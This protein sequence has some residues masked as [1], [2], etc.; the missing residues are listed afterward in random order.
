MKKTVFYAL[1]LSLLLAWPV[2]AAEAPPDTSAKAMILIHADS[3][4][5]LSEREADTPLPM[6]STTKLMTA[7]AAAEAADL[8][9]EIEIR[10]E[11]TAVEGSSM[12][13]RPGEK[14]TLRELLTGLLLASGN[15]AALALA[16]AV[17]GST[18]AFVERMNRRAAELGLQN[19]HFSNPHGLSAEDHFSCAR[20]LATLMRSVMENECLREILSLRECMIH[21]Q[22][23][24]NHNKLLSGC[25]G[26]DGGKTGFT[27]AAGRCLVS[28]CVRDGLRLICVTLSDPKDWADHEALYDWAYGQFCLWSFPGESDLPSVPVLW[29]TRTRRRPAP[30]AP[31][32][33]CVE[34]RTTVT[35]EWRVPTLLVSAPALGSE[36]GEARVYAG[37]ALA[38]RVPLI[39]VDAAEP[40]SAGRPFAGVCPV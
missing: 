31:V 9:A 17:D 10:P 39:W 24:Q 5:V 19:T 3:G 27:K 14:Y 2:R 35:V 26:V 29:G 1:A 20:D 34:Q 36:A 32:S 21:G 37:N 8:S 30:A 25:P 15:D 40:V 4:H 38:A 11:W 22:Y 12:Y 6:A 28:T 7:L 18:E 33:L 13:L 16:A 23:F